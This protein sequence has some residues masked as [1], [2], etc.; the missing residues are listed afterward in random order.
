MPVC[1]ANA[2]TS[3]WRSGSRCINANARPIRGSRIGGALYLGYAFGRALSMGIDGWPHESLTHATLVELAL[4]L[5]CVWV[6]ML[7][8]L[9]HNGARP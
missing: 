4:G 3:S 7:D 2:T 8:A 6:Y 1:L 9:P 5:A